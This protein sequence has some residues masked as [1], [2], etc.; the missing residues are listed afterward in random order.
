M[1]KC[2]CHT[3]KKDPHLNNLLQQP[4][5]NQRL[6]AGNAAQ[7]MGD[8]RWLERNQHPECTFCKLKMYIMLFWQE[9]P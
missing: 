2:N 7:M 1:Q 3:K 4:V 6:S 9:M 8:G 5:R